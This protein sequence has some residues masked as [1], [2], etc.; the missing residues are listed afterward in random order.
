[1]R[2][3]LCWILDC[4]LTPALPRCPHISWTHFGGIQHTPRW[5]GKYLEHRVLCWKFE[6]V[7]HNKLT[8]PGCIATTA[9]NPQCLYVRML[10]R[11]RICPAD[12]HSSTHSPCASNSHS[13]WWWDTVRQMYTRSPV[14]ASCRTTP[15]KGCVHPAPSLAPYCERTLLKPTLHIAWV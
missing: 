10:H 3:L 14:P 2:S 12:A 4:T 15:C 6:D 5:Q 9:L 7:A 8:C 11:Y 13:V 1:M